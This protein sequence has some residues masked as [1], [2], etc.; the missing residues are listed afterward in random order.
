LPCAYVQRARLLPTGTYVRGMWF[1]Y[2]GFALGTTLLGLI[3]LTIGL[4]VGRIGDAAR[5]V[6]RV[7]STPTLVAG[8]VAAFLF[9]AHALVVMA[10]ARGDGIV[11]VD[12]TV[13]DWFLAHRDSGTT[14][15]MRAA[16]FVG[17]SPATVVAVAV[18]VALLWWR[19]RRAGAAALA[20]AALGSPLISSGF[21]LLYRR[22][23]P[24]STDHLSVATGYALPSGHAVNSIVVIGVL[25]AACVPHVRRAW[26]RVAMVSA[27]AVAVAIVGVSRL[28]LGVHWSSDV[29]T[30]WLLGGAWVAVCV[31]AMLALDRRLR[32][33]RPD[34]ADRADVA[35]RDVKA[36]ER[37]RSSR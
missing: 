23:R 17:D 7:V 21:K 29:L 36:H 2:P 16:S 27:G 5:K 6:A 10:V 4:R 11:A 28:Y 25:V 35:A 12:R 3:G 26:E 18:A 22:E 30:G 1:A 24:P 20:I 34:H 15:L 32:S 19:G 33:P 37:T 8:A 13:L 31:A 14:T 9:T